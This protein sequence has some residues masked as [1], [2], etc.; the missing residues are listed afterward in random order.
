MHGDL[1]PRN[2]VVLD[3]KALL[4]NRGLA[5]RADLEGCEAELVELEVLFAPTDTLRASLTLKGNTSPFF[6]GSPSLH[7]RELT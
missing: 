5:P 7:L 2:M 4:I 3:G 1:A 6:I